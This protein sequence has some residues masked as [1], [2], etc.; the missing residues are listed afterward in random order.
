MLSKE[1]SAHGDVTYYGVPAG[2]SSLP[3]TQ[4]VI[5]SLECLI[6]PRG[7]WPSGQGACVSEK[8]PGKE[9]NER[10]DEKSQ[11]NFFSSVRAGF[12]A[13]TEKATKEQVAV[14]FFF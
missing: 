1:A 5:R 8:L 6:G 10:R 7:S 2:E 3:V 4:P 11:C 12:C 9:L 14:I 13:R